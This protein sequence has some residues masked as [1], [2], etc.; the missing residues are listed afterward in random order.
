MA[1]CN[2]KDNQVTG[3][4]S[5]IRFLTD[6]KTRRN[7]AAI[8]HDFEARR[9]AGNVFPP[10]KIHQMRWAMLCYKWKKGYPWSSMRIAILQANNRDHDDP[11]LGQHDPKNFVIK[12]KWSLKRLNLYQNFIKY[13]EDMQ[14][15]LKNFAQLGYYIE[16]ANY[17]SHF[18]EGG[19]LEQEAEFDSLLTQAKNLE[20]FIFIEERLEANLGA[21]EAIQSIRKDVQYNRF[22]RVLTVAF[23]SLPD[24]PNLLFYFFYIHT[25]PRED[26]TMVFGATFDQLNADLAKRVKPDDDIEF[27]CLNVGVLSPSKDGSRYI[28]MARGEKKKPAI[29]YLSLHPVLDESGREFH[30]LRSMEEVK[31]WEIR[32][33]I[34]CED[35]RQENAEI[36]K[37]QMRGSRVKASSTSFNVSACEH[38]GIQDLIATMKEPV[39]WETP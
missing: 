20:Q 8:Y 23:R 3:N 25:I 10:F 22:G 13:D 30:F 11:I 24:S 21:V 5:E 33:E 14:G 2:T 35:A 29:I 19:L 26:F 28:G 6:S 32:G 15:Y 1:I 36:F 31:K 12:G 39:L 16:A 9:V 7:I 27:S 18:D 37:A 34:R 4:S 17:F 38:S